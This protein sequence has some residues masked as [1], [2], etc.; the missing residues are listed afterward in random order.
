MNNTLKNYGLI[1]KKPDPRDYILGAAPIPFP[2]INEI[3]DWTDSLPVKEFQNLN[4][5]EP[6]ACVPFTILNCVETL[7]KYKYGIETNWSDR[8]LAAISDTRK[9][10]GSVPQDVCYLLHKMGVPPQ[11]VWPFD[12]TIDT[13]D[14]FF[15]PIPDEIHAIA[16]EFKVWDFKYAHV[17][18]TDFGIEEGLKRSPCLF[19]AAAW[20]EQNG[21]YYRPTGMEDNHAT[22][23]FFQR[24]EEFRRVFDTYDSPH[25]KDYRYSDLPLMAM[26][27]K[28][29][30]KTNVDKKP[31]FWEWIKAIIK[32]IFK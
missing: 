9:N 14:K 19:S 32:A 30:K 13:L 31:S 29:T 28:V 27:F 15:A 1:I 5:I 26:C 6:Y 7:I 4:N 10:N 8:F 25:I 21:L 11:K 23:L 22:T 3:G 18:A 20:F 12:E 24:K 17:P 16:E 2:V